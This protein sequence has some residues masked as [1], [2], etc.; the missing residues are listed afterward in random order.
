MQSISLCPA[1]MLICNTGDSKAFF[2]LSSLLNDRVLLP[3]KTRQTADVKINNSVDLGICIPH[4]TPAVH[5][6]NAIIM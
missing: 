1:L 3:G 2:Q 6:P 5:V 4:F